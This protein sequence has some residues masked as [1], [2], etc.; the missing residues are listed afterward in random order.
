MADAAVALAET[1]AVTGRWEEWEEKGDRERKEWEEAGD[2]ERGR[3]GCGA[4]RA[5]GFEREMGGVGMG[6]R[7][8]D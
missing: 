7:R 2:R 6:Q 3:S 1:V 8:R 4:E 5:M